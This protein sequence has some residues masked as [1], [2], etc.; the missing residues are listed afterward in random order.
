MT[1]ESLDRIRLYVSGTRHD[2]VVAA[3][4]SRLNGYHTIAME[5]ENRVV[6]A[7]LILADLAEIGGVAA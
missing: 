1:Q 2:D 7:D 6:L 5:H 4:N 3:S